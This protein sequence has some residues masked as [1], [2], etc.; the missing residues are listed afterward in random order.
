MAKSK[1]SHKKSSV[2]VEKVINETKL[3]LIF[4]LIFFWTSCKLE[5]N[6]SKSFI[7]ACLT[8]FP[9][10]PQYNPLLIPNKLLVWGLPPKLLQTLFECYCYKPILVPTQKTTSLSGSKAAWNLRGRYIVS[11]Y[12][13]SRSKVPPEHRTAYA[14]SI[15][16]V[17]N[18][19]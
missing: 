16:F 10:Q 15:T 12:L 13:A 11:T 18:Q 14:Y 1:S 6:K 8:C 19:I 5:T 7:I 2:Y 4:F 9:Y 3:E 17:F